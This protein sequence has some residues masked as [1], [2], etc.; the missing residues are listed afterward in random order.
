MFLTVL[1]ALAYSAC[2]LIEPR[3]PAQRWSHPQGAFPPWSL[4]EKIPHSW[5]SW[6][7][8]PKWSSFLYDNTSLCQVDTYNQPVQLWMIVNFNNL[9]K[10]CY[11]VMCILFAYMSVYHMCAWGLKRSEEGIRSPGTGV[12]EGCKLLCQWVLGI[13]PGSSGRSARHIISEQSVSD[14]TFNIWGFLGREGWGGAPSCSANSLLKTYRR[15]YWEGKMWH[16]R[17]SAFLHVTQGSQSP[18]GSVRMFSTQR[19][20]QGL[21]CSLALSLKR[22]GSHK[23][24]H[25]GR[26]L[27]SALAGSTRH[28]CR[29][30]S[31]Q[32][33]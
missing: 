5:I 27:A 32:A 13:K 15:K 11:M 20:N 31:W 26:S 1:L 7:H 25:L 30:Y 8:F 28:N 22:E 4:I 24:L 16:V 14:V 23:S 6:R 10:K 3:L 9:Q 18:R 19:Q 29:S 2:S 17:T 33:S 21:R 12:K